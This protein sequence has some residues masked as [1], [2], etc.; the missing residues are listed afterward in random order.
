[1]VLARY[2][3]TGGFLEQNG[4]G[5]RVDRYDGQ[6]KDSVLNFTPKIILGF[7]KSYLLSTSAVILELSQ[8]L[9]SISTR[10]RMSHNMNYL[11]VSQDSDFI[12]WFQTLSP[13]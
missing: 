5:F 12:K 13:F 1:M 7:P 3:C 2:N 11:Y 4:V 10:I 8:F 9:I 6:C